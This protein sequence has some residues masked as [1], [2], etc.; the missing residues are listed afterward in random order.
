[1]KEPRT[2][3]RTPTPGKQSTS[4]PT[5]KYEL[6]AQAIRDV[7]PPDEPGF[8]AKALPEAVAERL[9]P[10]DLARLG[11]VAWHTTS[12]KLNMEVE[13]EIERVPGSKPQRLIK[14]R[15]Q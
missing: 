10:E 11:S 9:E 3:C 12:V 7:L 13:G 5:W 2:V 1:M 15:A 14:S 6:V 4:I 8:L